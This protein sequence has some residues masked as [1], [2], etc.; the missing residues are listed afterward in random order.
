MKE[1]LSACV[2]SN[3]SYKLFKS[4]D[5]SELA[6]FIKA[7]NHAKEYIELTMR[8]NYLLQQAEIEYEN[9]GH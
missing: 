6:L 8:D 1:K 2:T 5:F 9:R 3:D 7:L 4:L